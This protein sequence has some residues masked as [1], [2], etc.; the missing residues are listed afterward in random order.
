MKLEKPDEKELA[1]VL[2]LWFDNVDF[3]LP[4]FLSRN[5]VARTLK[6]NL[7]VAGH[8]KNLPRGK[9]KP[10]LSVTQMLKKAAQNKRIA[11]QKKLEEQMS[12]F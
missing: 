9:N 4:N 10:Q 11:D 12:R 7:M 5:E 1:R 2:K 8:W 3:S 6:E